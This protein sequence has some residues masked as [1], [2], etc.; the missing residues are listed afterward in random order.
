MLLRF[1]ATESC[2]K[3]VPCRIG[4]T[5]ALE[6]LARLKDA[7]ATTDDLAQ[8]ERIATQMQLASFCGL[9]Q[10]AAVPILT[11]LRFFRDEFIAHA[12]AR[13]CAVNVCAMRGEP[14]APK[15]RRALPM[16]A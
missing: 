15:A 12:D 4:T 6:I 5:R 3:C 14:V 2:G 1:F 13:Q 9:G 11:G 8:L 10:A 16:A 7:R